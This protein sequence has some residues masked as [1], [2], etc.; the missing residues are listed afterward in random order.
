MVFGT[1]GVMAIVSYVSYLIAEIM[2][3][4]TKDDINTAFTVVDTRAAAE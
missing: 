3:R 1:L 2:F 4:L